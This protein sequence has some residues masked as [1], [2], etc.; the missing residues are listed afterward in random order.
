MRLFTRVF[1]VLVLVGHVKIIQSGYDDRLAA[2]SKLVAVLPVAVLAVVQSYAVPDFNWWCIGT[3][4]H[5]DSFLFLII[6]AWV[7]FNSGDH[8]E[9][10]E[11][12]LTDESTSFCSNVLGD[13]GVCN[14]DAVCDAICGRRG[15]CHDGW[16]HG[17]SEWWAGWALWHEALKAPGDTL[18][19]FDASAHQGSPCW[20]GL[21]QMRR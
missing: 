10:C 15:S 7:R 21:R 19:V 20:V 17:S 3:E 18:S 16:D 4:L 2:V 12:L 1:V 5:Y 11:T 8:K 9:K 6:R 13:N 14:C